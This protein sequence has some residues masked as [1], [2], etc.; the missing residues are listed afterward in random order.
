MKKTLKIILFVGLGI[1]MFFL[2]VTWLYPYSFFSINKT[3]TFEPYLNGVKHYR[4]DIQVIKNTYQ[5]NDQIQPIFAMYEQKWLI[6]E[7]KTQLKYDDIDMI[8]KK[9]KL[10]RESLTQLDLESIQ[11]N[12]KEDKDIL[13]RECLTF[14]KDIKEIKNSRNYSRMKIIKQYSDLNAGFDTSI[15]VFGDFY[16]NYVRD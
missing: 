13:I 7:K 3:V 4:K 1:L 11:P 15:K 8:L 5:S 12:E 10:G 6:R 9:V 16:K 2:G 14:E